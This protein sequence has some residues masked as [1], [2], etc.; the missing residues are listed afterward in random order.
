V[1][2]GSGCDPL[3]AN[4]AGNCCSGLS[5]P[6]SN[7]YKQLGGNG[8]PA[9]PWGKGSDLSA[10]SG[11]QSS[12]INWRGNVYGQPREYYG[13]NMPCSGL[14]A[15]LESEGQGQG[16]DQDQEEGVGSSH[17]EEA[18]DALSIVRHPHRPFS[19]PRGRV[20]RQYGGGN[21]NVGPIDRAPGQRGTDGTSW[22]TYATLPKQRD[23][24]LDL[25]KCPFGCSSHKRSRGT[26]HIELEHLRTQHAHEGPTGIPQG[27]DKE[28]AD[29]WL[30]TYG[31]RL[32]Y[33]H[34]RYLTTKKLKVDGGSK[35][36]AWAYRYAPCPDCPDDAEEVPY[37]P[38]PGSVFRNGKALFP[39]KVIVRASIVKPKPSTNFVPVFNLPSLA[40]E[41]K[42]GHV[43]EKDSRA[44]LSPRTLL[45]SKH[46]VLATAMCPA[47]CASHEYSARTLDEFQKH[48]RNVHVIGKPKGPP[49]QMHHARIKSFMQYHCGWYCD[50]H[51]KTYE[52]RAFAKNKQTG[53]HLLR[54]N[55]CGQCNK[56]PDFVC[57]AARYFVSSYPVFI[58]DLQV[59]LEPEEYAKLTLLRNGKLPIQDST[60]VDLLK[61]DRESL[62]PSQWISDRVV[63]AFAILLNRRCLYE[64]KNAL[65]VSP[66]LFHS[67]YIM[68]KSTITT[69][70]RIS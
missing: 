68:G 16:E 10:A 35:A 44:W 53:E 23:I 6:L 58:D 47:G 39:P 43:D 69:V 31:V 61:E 7:E 27:L 29:A 21:T 30:A 33:L 70:P 63:G 55:A 57:P 46:R 5:R 52:G 1:C 59:P 48:M 56:F 65:M 28:T 13:E 8:D 60:P 62:Q 25:T 14:C 54:Y 38:P 40:T 12:L 49:A 36:G 64:G 11:G 20:G 24:I 26:L 34:G 41:Q 42:I 22:V 15:H 66:E 45:P 51:N 2:S 3:L 50:I 67:Q 19:A 9:P 37:I 18:L 17:E 32:C 4:T